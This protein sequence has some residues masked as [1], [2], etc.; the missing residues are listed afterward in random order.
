MK[1]TEIKLSAAALFIL[2]GILSLTGC[3]GGG[4]DGCPDVGH[5]VTVP[6]EPSRESAK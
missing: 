3:G 4:D 5:C 6:D 2:F 1:T